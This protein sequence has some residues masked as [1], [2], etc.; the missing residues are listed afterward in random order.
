M[1]TRCTIK[2]EGVK[3]CKVYKHYDGYPE[4]TLKW[5]QDFNKDFFEKR[6]D[7]AQYKIA[8]LLRSSAFD[9]EKYRLDNGRYTGWGIV[10]YNANCGEE[11]EYI[12]KND[13][14][15]ECKEIK[16]C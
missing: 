13:G 12:L 10:G 6:G 9:S 11:F 5:L 2:I 1:A 8:Q 16:Q 3:F 4:A 15:V 14:T 7:D